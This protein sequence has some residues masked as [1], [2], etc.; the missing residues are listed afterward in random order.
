[1]SIALRALTYNI[2]EGGRTRQSKITEVIRQA[3]PD[4]V[5]LQE[6]NDEAFFYNLAQELKMNPL[7]THVR[8]GYNVGLLSRYPVAEWQPHNDPAIFRVGAVQARLTLPDGLLNVCSLHLHA[9]YSAEYEE[10]RT[11]ETQAIAAI[12]QPHFGER[13][14][15]MGDFNTLS[16][17]DILKPE[18]WPPA[19]LRRMKDMP[20]TALAVLLAAGYHDCFREL[21]ADEQYRDGYTLPAVQPNVRLDYIFASP[22]HRASLTNCEVVTHADAGNASDHLPVLADFRF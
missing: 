17:H 13:T 5:A 14:L 12:M 15:L 3:N 1:M 6:V 20:R 2:W 16:P 9:K 8:I 19:F 11:A 21:F 7:L 18:D 10:K 22:A 4:I